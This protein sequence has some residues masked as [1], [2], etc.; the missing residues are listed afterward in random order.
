MAPVDAKTVAV[1]NRL[2]SYNNSLV[3]VK[4]MLWTNRS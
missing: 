2:A 3:L 1:V 4:V